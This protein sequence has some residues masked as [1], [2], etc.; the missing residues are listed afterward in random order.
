[1]SKNKKARGSDR[2]AH[3][4]SWVPGRKG[5]GGEGLSEGYGGAGD[6]T[7]A[8]GPDS[9]KRSKPQDN[10]ALQKEIDGS[11]DYSPSLPS[12]ED[13]ARVLR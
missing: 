2:N 9:G 11:A 5:Q 12:R 3:G 1:M 6:G 13:I 7:G 8:S 10:A 4:K